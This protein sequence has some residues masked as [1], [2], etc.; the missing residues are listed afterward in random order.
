MMNCLFRMALISAVILTGSSV[1]TFA[2]SQVGG[3]ISWCQLSTDLKFAKQICDGIR[4]QIKKSTSEIG[5]PFIDGASIRSKDAENFFPAV[6]REK[7]GDTDVEN[8]IHMVIEV[9]GTK[10]ATPGSATTVTAGFHIKGKGMGAALGNISEDAR[11]V[12]W[13]KSLLATGPARKLAPN[14]VQV[15]GEYMNELFEKLSR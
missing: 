10:G 1:A 11:I 14:V 13:Q 12:V 5:L 15:M 4:T 7:A 3:V 9:R 2:Q 8:Y 6:I